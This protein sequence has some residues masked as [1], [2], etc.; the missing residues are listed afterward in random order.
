MG[1]K[2][3][4]TGIWPGRFKPVMTSDCASKERF[5]DEENEMMTESNRN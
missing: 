1:T 4:H 5:Q 3:S 2:L